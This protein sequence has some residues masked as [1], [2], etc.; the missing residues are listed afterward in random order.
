MKT[1]QLLL[2]VTLLAFVPFTYGQSKSKAKDKTNLEPQDKT[3]SWTYPYKVSEERAK[4]LEQKLEKL[5][6]EMPVKDVLELLGE[7]DVTADLTKKF[8]ELSYY[9]SGALARNEKKL[10]LR[11]VWYFRKYTTLPSLGDK[12]IAAYLSED[13]KTVLFYVE[14]NVKKK[15]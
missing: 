1:I 10:S 3:T 15:E 9:E 14:N 4:E 2:I 7:P 11:F 13:K 8:E 5:K 6:L 12:W